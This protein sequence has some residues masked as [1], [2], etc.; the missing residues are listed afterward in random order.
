MED[1]VFRGEER[2][3]QKMADR[4]RFSVRKE[5]NF[6]AGIDRTTLTKEQLPEARIGKR[7]DAIFKPKA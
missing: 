4:G 6:V 2:R 3:R 5:V 7:V 1:V